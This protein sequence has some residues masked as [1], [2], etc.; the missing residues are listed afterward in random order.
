MRRIG[1][2]LTISGRILLTGIFVMA[3]L[4]G[5]VQPGGIVVN[6]S[7]AKPGQEVIEAARGCAKTN[8]TPPANQSASGFMGIGNGPNPVPAG[9]TC[10]SGDTCNSSGSTC[11]FTWHCKNTYTYP[12]G[13]GSG[14]CVS[15]CMP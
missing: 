7:K 11:N 2:C 6:C 14:G 15:G 5:C 1:Q 12:A 9:I 4:Q 8:L 13:G 10:S 3:F